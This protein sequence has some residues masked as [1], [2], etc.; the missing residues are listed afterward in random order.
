M[1]L[2]FINYEKEFYNLSYTDILPGDS[3]HRNVD[4]CEQHRGKNLLHSRGQHGSAGCI[5]DLPSY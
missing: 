3:T 4:A 5:D 1:E 2:L